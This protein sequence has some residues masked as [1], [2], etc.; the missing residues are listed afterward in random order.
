MNAVGD[1]CLKFWLFTVSIQ[2]VKLL[3]FK[4]SNSFHLYD[5][6]SPQHYA[7]WDRKRVFNILIISP[8]KSSQHPVYPLRRVLCDVLRWCPP[9][10]TSQYLQCISFVPQSHLTESYVRV[11]PSLPHSF[12]WGGVWNFDLRDILRFL[13]A[14]EKT[15]VCLLVFG[16]SRRACHTISG[17]RHC[18]SSY[19]TRTTW[20]SQGASTVP[21]GTELGTTGRWILYN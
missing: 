20:K 13:T 7:N 12:H 18:V 21:R 5:T 15:L 8:F 11:V 4:Y 3:D 16:F 2:A 10:S 19:I 6:N 17:A 1:I 14:R 9:T